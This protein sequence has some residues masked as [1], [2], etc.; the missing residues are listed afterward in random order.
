MGVDQSRVIIKR[1]EVTN[2]FT[3]PPAM[4]AHRVIWLIFLYGLQN[5]T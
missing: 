1:L 5:I 3:A 4:L 2:L